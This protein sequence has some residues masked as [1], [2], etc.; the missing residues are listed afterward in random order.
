MPAPQAASH[1][2]M[3]AELRPT[4]DGVWAEEASRGFVLP[5]KWSMSTAEDS[6]EAVGSIV[7]EGPSVTKVQLAL[8]R[9]LR[10]DGGLEKWWSEEAKLTDVTGKTRIQSKRAQAQR[11]AEVWSPPVPSQPLQVTAGCDEFRFRE[12]LEV[13]WRSG[14]GKEKSITELRQAV[15]HHLATAPDLTEVVIS[16]LAGLLHSPEQLALGHLLVDSA[17]RLMTKRSLVFQ[18][19]VLL[20]GTQQAWDMILAQACVPEG[21]FC[22]KLAAKACRM[23]A[24]APTTDSREAVFQCLRDFFVFF[25]FPMHV[26]A[27]AGCETALTGALQLFELQLRASGHSALTEVEVTPL[28]DWLVGLG[29]VVIAKLCVQPEVCTWAGGKQALAGLLKDSGQSRLAKKLEERP[30]SRTPKM[31]Q[32]ETQVLPTLALS[33]AVVVHW[34]ES[35]VATLE[36]LLFAAAADEGAP[37][38]IALDAEWKPYTKGAPPTNVELV[39]LAV[40]SQIWLLDM[41]R[42]VQTHPAEITSLFKRLVS[43]ECILLGFGLGGDLKRIAESYECLNWLMNTSVQ[44]AEDLNSCPGSLCDSVRER[45]GHH[46]EKAQQCSDW[47]R[48]PLSAEQLH[49]AALDAH[50]LLQLAAATAAADRS[51]GTATTIAGAT[52]TSLE[53]RLLAEALK[54][55]SRRDAAPLFAPLGAS[56]V[57]AALLALGA[58]LSVSLAAAALGSGSLRLARREELVPLFGHEPGSLGPVGLRS[59]GVAVLV[60]V[61]LQQESHLRVGSGGSQDVVLERAALCQALGVTFAPI[62]AESM[63]KR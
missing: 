48:R 22:P 3:V 43:G 7:E 54:V 21:C 60:D 59:T 33:E 34:V 61:A 36:S 14:L 35:E 16:C 31:S 26:P 10:L 39:Q 42:L 27:S 5:P 11:L 1:P 46:L 63:G 44:L 41:P 52:G 62:A 23:L 53:P 32:E 57:Q 12:V 51:N 18:E 56:H 20:R 24:L 50:V 37:P 2:I 9:M 25:G 15:L 30:P 45:L 8:E 38:F 47:S 6:C 29:E 13:R 4:G 40:A 17:K 58:M 55:R 49:Y 28:L 19:R